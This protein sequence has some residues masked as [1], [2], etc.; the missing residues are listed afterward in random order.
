MSVVGSMRAAQILGVGRLI[1][2]MCEAKTDLQL[3][4]RHGLEAAQHLLFRYAA[5]GKDAVK[6]RPVCASPDVPR[7]YSSPKVRVIKGCQPLFH[8]LNVFKNNHSR[9][10]PDHVSRAQIWEGKP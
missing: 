6:M 3:D 1:D 7:L 5:F 2:A 8:V 9:I 4:P 10:V